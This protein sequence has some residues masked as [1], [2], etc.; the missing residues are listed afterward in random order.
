MTYCVTYAP[1]WSV[2][3]LT[4]NEN[5]KTRLQWGILFCGLDL[6]QASKR[7][8]KT[9]LQ[10]N[11]WV[12]LEYLSDLSN[13]SRVLIALIRWS[14]SWLW[15]YVSVCFYFFGIIEFWVTVYV[16]VISILV[17]STPKELIPGCISLL[18][19]GWYA[20][21]TMNMKGMK[22]RFVHHKL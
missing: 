21:K 3:A 6:H 4:K 5:W 16:L 8:W 10:G 13:A 22:G 12:G 20:Y 9:R 14:K 17:I 1:L 2:M 19:N 11:I 18:A 7:N 15:W